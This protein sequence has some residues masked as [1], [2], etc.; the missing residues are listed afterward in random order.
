MGRLSSD[1]LID[2]LCD[3]LGHPHRRTLCT[4]FASAEGDRF[5]YSDLVEWI[6]ESDVTTGNGT[7]SGREA[8]EMSLHHLHLPKLAEHDVI[9]YD[10]D[11]CAV[12][13]L[14]TPVTAL[15]ESVCREARLLAGDAG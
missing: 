11:E 6:L 2:A 8:V 1:S 13:Y 5:S 7:A 14:D 12:Q 15:S 10:P 3:V 4:R 9:H